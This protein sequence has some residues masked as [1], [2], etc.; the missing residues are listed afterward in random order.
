MTGF[1]TV[2]P[3]VVEVVGFFVVV[4]GGFVVAGLVVVGVVVGLV[5]VVVVVVVVAG[6]FTSS[7]TGVTSVDGSG[8]DCCLANKS[9]TYLSKSGV[10]AVAAMLNRNL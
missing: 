4:V 10:G 7:I 5:V 1:L 2:V 8:I 9:E 3:V 6:G